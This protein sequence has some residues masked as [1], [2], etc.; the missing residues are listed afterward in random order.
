MD[1][2]L[3]TGARLDG[4]ENSGIFKI[5]KRKCSDH[6]IMTGLTWRTVGFSK[7]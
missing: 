7:E 3:I 1:I 6:W 5:M 2:I 4:M